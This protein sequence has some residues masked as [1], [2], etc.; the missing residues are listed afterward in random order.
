MEIAAKKPLRGSLSS[1]TG[2]LIFAVIAAIIAGALVFAAIHDARK[3]AAA[4]GSAS[5]VVA[6]QLIPKG[7]SGAA[8]AAD[9]SFRLADI[10]GNAVVAG[11]IT[12]ISQ[13]TDKV[14]TR[15][16]YPG[17]QLAAS[18]FATGDG[19]LTAKLAN[20][21]RA[22]ALPIDQAHGLIGNVRAG[23][24]VDVL[25][26]FNEQSDNGRT[27]PVMRA[28]ASNV[29]VLKAPT[30][31]SGTASGGQVVTLAVRARTATQLAFT[32]DNGKVWIVLRGGGSKQ[33]GSGGVVTMSD[34]LF[35]VKPVS[36]Q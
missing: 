4:G 6:K 20:N 15:D 16:V 13:V 18:D 11:A 19:S 10:K 1:R 17:Q 8:I 26:G 3:T 5:V 30:S 35:G 12:D 31:G 9:Q 21:E 29:K 25:V 22:V 36:G 28:L 7:S 34:V 23:D 24:R 33:R 27:R 14:A 32:A 2:S